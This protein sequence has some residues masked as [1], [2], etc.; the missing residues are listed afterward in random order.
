MKWIA[1]RYPAFFK[2]PNPRVQQM[3][4]TG[5]YTGNEKPVDV[6]RLKRMDFSVVWKLS[7]D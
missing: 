7:D 3:A 2:P 6:Q 5:A 1:T 4:G